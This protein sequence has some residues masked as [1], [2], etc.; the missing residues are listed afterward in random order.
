MNKLL[1]SKNLILFQIGYNLVIKYCIANWG[2]P[3]FLNY[4][5]DLV[6][7][8]LLYKI[9]LSTSNNNKI[10]YTPLV[11]LVLIFLAWGLITFIFNWYNPLYLLW[12]LRNSFRFY[13]FLVACVVFLTKEDIYIIFDILY[14]FFICNLIL[15][16]IQYWIQNLRMDFVSGLYSMGESSG[17]NGALN[18]LMVLICIIIIVRYIQK[19]VSI[20]KTCVVILGSFYMATLS[21]LKVVYMEIIL[22][23]ILSIL[24]TKFS[25]RKLILILSVGLSLYFAVQ[26]LYEY[27]P[28]FSE[29][30]SL[31]T[32]LD[33]AS[34]NQGYTSNNDIN[35]LSSIQY[36]FNNFLFG[37]KSRI[38]GVGLGNADYSSNFSFLTT[39]FYNSYSDTNYTWFSVPF[40]LIEM[41]IIGLIL[42]F[43]VFILTFITAVK[44]KNCTKDTKEK[45]LFII[46]QITC[47][48]SVILSIYNSSLRIESAGYM[49]Y[50]ILSIPFILQYNFCRL[51][52]IKRKKFRIVWSK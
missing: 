25:F 30:F 29:F 32:I 4:V 13:V 1:N 49:L 20:Y 17:G 33:Y 7:V 41:G 24:F 46:S 16:S 37:L 42:F 43:M 47:A 5:S 10:L 36:V 2:F 28:I 45:S 12:G 14:F 31:Q 6:T 34:G 40:I 19:E 11:K 18:M 35:R 27:Y 52:K 48:M 50:A 21:E 38:F 3:S 8:I 9:I 22:I 44:L 51:R 26:M 15:V 23:V 39:P